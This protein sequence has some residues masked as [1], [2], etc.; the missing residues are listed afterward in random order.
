MAAGSKKQAAQENDKESRSL[1]E[2]LDEIDEIVEKLDDD[3][4]P[5]EEAFA[6]YSRGVK[7]TE[8][9]SRS[10]DRVEKKVQKLM[11]DGSTED[12]D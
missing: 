8:E 7:L 12:F 10:I 3:D 11:D 2:M 4:L 6:L 1:E 9:S 5:L